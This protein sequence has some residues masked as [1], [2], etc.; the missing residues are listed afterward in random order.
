M[1][2][3]ADKGRRDVKFAV[4]D[5]VVLSTRNMKQS[6]SRK[7]NARWTG[8]FTI[9]QMVGPD[10]RPAVAARLA[11]PPQWRIHPVFH[12]SLLKHY[13][14]DGC[15]RPPPP[16]M[17]YDGDGNAVW[18]VSHLLDERTNPVTG[19]TEF[20]VRWEGYDPSEDSWSRES[21]ILDKTLIL[22]YRARRHVLAH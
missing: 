14:P 6:G 7:F 19:E 20:K 4:G 18:K 2:D 22:D 13:H 11:L 16:P 21:D 1:K 3:R 5:Q 10:G 17:G 8:P 12:V 15:S 9:T